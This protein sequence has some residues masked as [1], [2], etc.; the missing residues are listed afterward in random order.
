ML[1]LGIETS[2]DETAAA[3]LEDGKL[4][5]SNIIRSQIDD[6]SKYGG[7]VPEI[8]SRKHIENIIQ[9]IDAAINGSDIRSIDNLDLIAVTCG[10]GLIGSL[11]IGVCVAK[12]L[13]FSKNIPLIAIDHLEGHIYSSFL[14]EP[15]I[16]FPFLSF[17]I[18]GGHTDIYLV[19]THGKYILLG[20]TRDDAAGEAFDKVAK[21]LNLGYPG[22][23]IISHY[24]EQGNPKAIKFPRANLGKTSLDFSFSGLKTSVFNYIK[25]TKPQTD[26]INDIAASFQESVVDMLTKTI[27]RALSEKKVNTITL[28]G[29]VASNLRL[30]HRLKQELG[31]KNIKLII[32]PTNL[33]TDNAAMIA[34][35]GYYNRGRAKF[36]N[37][38]QNA[39]NRRFITSQNINM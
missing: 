14:T 33:C 4:I 21:I 7:V 1:I 22:G 11:L 17:I 2:C 36:N 23:P 15:D 26:K 24:S 38:S 10:P 18:S 32:P 19:E 37:F 25:T 9:V 8:A 13:S 34:A 20:Q 35:A 27:L 12:S 3:V 31:K 6:H 16:K 30:R 5:L 29:G 39:T 28:G